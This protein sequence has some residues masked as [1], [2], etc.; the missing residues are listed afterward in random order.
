MSSGRNT[1]IAWA[2]IVGAVAV[3][4]FVAWAGSQDG[5]TLLGVPVMA[6]CAILS[7]GVQW[8]AFVPAYL[9][10]TERFYDLVGSLTYLTV[11]AFAIGGTQSRDARSWV[12]GLLVGVW[13][14][15]L[16][17]FLFRRIRSE[18][19]DGRFDEIKQSAS[20]FFVAWT[21]QG[22]WVFLTLCA[23]LAAITTTAPADLGVLDGVGFSIWLFGFCLEVIADRQKSEFRR[24]NPGR[25][26][27]TGL[28]AWSRHPNYFGE[29]V[30]WTGIA[31]MASSTLNGWQWITLVSPLFVTLLLTRIS[32]IPLLEKRADERWGDDAGY[33]AYK[34][35]TPVLI[36]RP[37]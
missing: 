2:V 7:F 8:L 4:G 11:T 34:A 24:Q 15:R 37:P 27:D 9:R 10:R 23:A 6:S 30:L 19:S 32:G 28:W 35:R 21:L 29:I 12:L 1:A 13:A 16:G 18:G 20:R 26:I 25:Y 31:V 36:P 33:Q 17:S 22:L 5:S 3:A 14:V